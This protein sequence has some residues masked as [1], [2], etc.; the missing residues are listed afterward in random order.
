MDS[1]YLAVRLIENCLLPPGG[2]I[3]LA[4]AT[5]L[6][7]PLF[8]RKLMLTLLTVAILLI[9]FTAL[10]VTTRYLDSLL[11]TPEPFDNNGQ[12][13]EVIVVL[14][15]SRYRNAPEYGGDTLFGF[16]LERIRYAAWLHKKIGLPL[17][18]TGGT[19]TGE[20]VSEAELMKNSLE[21]E[22][23]V[24]V[25]WV[26]TKSKTTWENALYSAEL[27]KQ[28]NIKTIA[29]VTHT[30]HMP[31]AKEA[32][33]KNGLIVIPA[34]TLYY[35]QN[36]LTKGLLGWIPNATSQYQNGYLFHEIVGGWWYKFKYH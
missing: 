26:E 14:G 35:R 29:L 9:Y 24:P 22:F 10:P 34:A 33:E 20:A 28:H 23:S 16:A 18:T 21:K 11:A 2:P 19:P 4:L 12:N 5:L 27:L 3:F 15:A 7:A 30:W 36:P 6:L 31:R 25:Q 8:R 17:L 32:F 13:A 1:G